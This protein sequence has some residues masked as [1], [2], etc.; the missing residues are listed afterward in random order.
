S[1]R[2][3][4]LR[5]SNMRQKKQ[6]PRLTINTE[7]T[8]SMDDK[9]IKSESDHDVNA[10]QD[11]LILEEDEFMDSEAPKEESKIQGLSEV[12]EECSDNNTVVKMESDE[13]DEEMREFE[14]ST[15][16]EQ[17]IAKSDGDDDGVEED[18][19]GGV[20][21]RRT[22]AP[23]RARMNTVYNKPRVTQA[24]RSSTRN[25]KIPPAT[26]DFKGRDV[27]FVDPLD[28]KADFWWPAMIV[29]N[30]E[31]DESMD[32]DDKL[33]ENLLEG[34]FLV[35]YFEDMT[36]SVVE[37]RGLR[38]FKI[39]EGP[40]LQFLDV[41]GFSSHIGVRRALKCIRN[42]EPLKSFKWDYWK[43]PVEN[44]EM[45]SSKKIDS[46]AKK[47]KKATS[48]TNTEASLELN[49][50]TRGRGQKHSHK[51]MNGPPSSNEVD[52]PAADEGMNV[53]NELIIPNKRKSSVST[54][55]RRNSKSISSRK[56]S[57]TINT[58]E[59]EKP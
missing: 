30:D 36:Y 27:V 8:A 31:I 24:R 15:P 14:N 41:E 20:A 1:K 25:A 44:P 58:D 52:S 4:T 33:E 34:K 55:S 23:R 59:E 53:D 12:S 22:L 57:T 2:K 37:A 6:P 7:I 9:Q 46:P 48:P 47:L 54:S 49:P 39:D 50:P 18:E 13:H 17:E 38:H 19:D 40:Y 29:P 10:G 5:Q 26:N 51:S 16:K 32:V 43:R 42:G 45:N 11:D 3:K 56:N 21:P 35:R 28:A